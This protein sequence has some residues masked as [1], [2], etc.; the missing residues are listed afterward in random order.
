MTWSR[1][2]HTPPIDITKPAC[3]CRRMVVREQVNAAAIIRKRNPE[4]RQ[5]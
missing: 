1:H 5:A 4:Q 3:S 2:I